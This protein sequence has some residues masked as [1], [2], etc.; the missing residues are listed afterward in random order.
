[1]S[2]LLVIVLSHLKSLVSYVQRLS[3]GFSRQKAEPSD[4]LFTLEG[5]SLAQLW[6]LQEGGAGGGAGRCSNQLTFR[7]YALG[8]CQ[9]RAAATDGFVDPFTGH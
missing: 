5:C 2:C 7:S 3:G 8:C 6:L 4:A 9:L 1:M